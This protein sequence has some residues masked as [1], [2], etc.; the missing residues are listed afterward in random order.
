MFIKNSFKNQLFDI[1]ENNFNN[2]A[3]DLFFYQAQRIEIYKAY[4][5]SLKIDTNLITH[6]TQIPFLP[7]GFFK[8]HQIIDPFETPKV[9]FKSSGTTGIVRSSHYV[10][11]PEFYKEVSRHIFEARFGPITNY[12]ILAFLPSY[13][14]NSHSSLIFMIDYFLTLTDGGFVSKS[15]DFQFFFKNSRQKI[16]LLFG[17]TYALLDLETT[18]D[19]ANAIIIETGGMKGRGKELSRD[20]VHQ[21]LIE[22]FGVKRVCAEYGMTELLSQAYSAGEGLFQTPRWMKF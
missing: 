13:Q 16:N 18:V 14:E 17:V 2:K 6:Y 10:A 15:E 1:D 22:R 11:D 4:I 20:E 8:N 12:N 5:D 3:L 7:I 19:L 9:I 21:I